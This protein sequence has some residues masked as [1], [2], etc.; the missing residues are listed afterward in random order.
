MGF[1]INSALETGKY[2]NISIRAVKG[3]IKKGRLFAFLEEKLSDDID[4]S[5]YDK[6]DRKIINEVFSQLLEIDESRKLC[7]E[8]NGLHLLIAYMFELMQNKKSY[9][10]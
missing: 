1:Y 10:S 5:I 2:S 3:A 6:T 4:F 7:V 9:L 8:N